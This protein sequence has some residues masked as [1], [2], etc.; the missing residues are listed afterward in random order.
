M[1]GGVYMEFILIIGMI[2]WI[3]SGSWTKGGGKN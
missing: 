3:L 1:K 2:G